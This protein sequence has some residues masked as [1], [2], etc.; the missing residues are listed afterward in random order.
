L[1]D[2]SLLDR[3]YIVR[4]N[5]GDPVPVLHTLNE[6]VDQGRLFFLP[7]GSDLPPG[8]YPIQMTLEQGERGY[9]IFSKITLGIFEK[10]T[11]FRER[12]IVNDEMLE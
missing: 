12:G 3:R 4:P 5:S 8:R 1:A 9:L 10:R 6:F 11:F 2:W 7:L